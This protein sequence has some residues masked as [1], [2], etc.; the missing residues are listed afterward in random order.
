VRLR[1]V[2]GG[3]VAVAVAVVVFFAVRTPG[4]LES[5][6]LFA[7]TSGAP[8]QSGHSAPPFTLPELGSHS[9]YTLASSDTGGVTVLN[10]WATW[11]HYCR[12][13][14]PLL[15]K[16][17]ADSN[18][19]VHVIGIDYTSEETSV[20]VVSSFVRRLHVRYPVLLDETGAT[21]RQY[22]VKAY[23]TTYFVNAKGVI[24]G[25]VI[26]QLTP[27]ILRL[28]LAAAGAKGVPVSA[29]KSA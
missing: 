5:P 8:A 1:L 22:G 10:F 11:C 13:E 15:E 17:A 4:A 20:A 6:R 24:T 16:L 19:R 27:A 29:G 12:Q 2:L 26:G 28:E 23:P 18:G 7:S 14:M 21:F 3:A 25:T 9:A